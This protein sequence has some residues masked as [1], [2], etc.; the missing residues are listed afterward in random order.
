MK[1]KEKAV[2]K[3][4]NKVYELVFNL[5]E[6]IREQQKQIDELKKYKDFIVGDLKIK[7]NQQLKK[8]EKE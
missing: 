1:P 2:E 8:R 7:Y 4:N 6:K 3:F 5:Q